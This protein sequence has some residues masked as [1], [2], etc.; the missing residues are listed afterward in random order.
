[1]VTFV[2]I[3]VR[4]LESDDGEIMTNEFTLASTL[5]ER[6]TDRPQAM[7]KDMDA[8][9]EKIHAD[10]TDYLNE[11]WKEGDFTWKEKEGDFTFTDALTNF[12][13][14]RLANLSVIVIHQREIINHLLERGKK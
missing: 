10:F 6:I 14:Q 5:I 2:N 8:A 4:G 3:H 7:K 1:M 12:L 13:L 11:L 9:T